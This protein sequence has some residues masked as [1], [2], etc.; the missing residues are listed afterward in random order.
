MT[1]WVL[2]NTFTLGTISILYNNLLQEDE[3]DVRK[4][5]DLKPD[6]MIKI[7]FIL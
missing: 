7:L 6:E 5:F 2:V 1:L 4:K 3:N